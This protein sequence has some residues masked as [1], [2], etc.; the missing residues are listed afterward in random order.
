MCNKSYCCCH[1]H[2]YKVYMCAQEEPW[3]PYCKAEWSMG[4]V[5]AE[6]R[7]VGMSDTHEWFCVSYSFV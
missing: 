1:K 3:Q 5:V 7:N 6:Q 2:V 4:Q